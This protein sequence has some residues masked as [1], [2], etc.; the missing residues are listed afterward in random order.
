MQGRYVRAYGTCLAVLMADQASKWVIL[1][2][3]PLGHSIPVVD[4][5]FSVVHVRNYGS[6]F[7]FLNHAD[8]Q[9]QR[10]FF[11]I[12]SIVAMGIIAWL[13]RQT[14]ER[15]KLMTWGIGLVMGGA[16]GNLVDRLRL[17][18]VV[19]FLD[20]FWGPLHWP[21]FNVADSA[22]CVGAGLLLLAF[23]RSNHVPDAH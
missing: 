11:I 9:W 7:G 1:K 16:V 6:A 22:I 20:V 2:N 8:T 23:T 13:L 4:G 14:T 5:L 3:L 15:D 10:W 18:S 17:G 19:D 21:A 12:S